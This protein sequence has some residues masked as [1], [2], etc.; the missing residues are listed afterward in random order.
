M[1]RRRL[2]KTLFCSSVAMELNLLSP[3]ARAVEPAAA[4]NLG[5]LD[6]LVMGD[7][8]S[9]DQAQ[10]DLASGLVKYATGLGKPTQGM[11]LL[12]DNFYH[13]MPG[14]FES[15]RWKTGFSELYPGS[16]FPGPC[17][18]ILG[19]HDY[20]DTVG[21]EKV[22]LGYADFKNYKTRWTMPGKYYRVDLPKE[23]PQVTFLM[24]DTNWEPINR[25]IHGNHAYCWTSN[26]EKAEQM[27][28][29][30]AQLTLKRAPFTVVVGHHPLYSDGPH[31]DTPEL[32]QELGPIFEKHGVHMYL[33]GHDHDLQHLELEGLR[34]SFVTSG[35][36]GAPLHG[37]LPPRKGAVMKPVHGFTHLTVSDKRL[38]VRHFDKG[39]QLLHAFSKGTAYDWK[40]ES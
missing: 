33:C 7:F 15:P 31:K 2:L 14:G 20:H 30:E 12:G 11:L 28:W 19:N 35:G 8:G 26:A 24:I 32:V 23:A 17:W 39:G 6:L 1:T 29:L 22:Q 18:A 21:N 16:V 9:A 27:A 38:Q 4:G 13:P 34:T 5:S 3:R 36:G 37:D 10:K 40:L 25:R